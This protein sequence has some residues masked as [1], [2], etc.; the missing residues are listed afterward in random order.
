MTSVV[1]AQPGE[2]QTRSDTSPS[3]ADEL[4]RRHRVKPLAAAGWWFRTCGFLLDLPML[5]AWVLLSPWI[6]YLVVARGRSIG[7]LQERFGIWRISLPTRERI[8]IH[9]ASVG[10]VRASVSL[11]DTLRKS[12]P[13]SEMVIST[14]T[15]GARDL[16]R[17]LFD[18][19]QVHLLPLDFSPLVQAVLKRL[20]PD[21][22]ILIELE[23]WPNLLLACRSRSIPVVVM[24]GRITAK[25][26]GRLRMLGPLT[27]WMASCPELICARS[28][29][30]ASRF[31]QLGVAPERVR[32]PGD[33]KLDSLRGPDP[34]SRRLEFDRSCGV[35]V[36]LFRWS[37]GCT[38]PGEEELMLAAH[39][40]LL[41]VWPS[42]QLWIGPR[43]VE[44]AAEVVALVRRCGLEGTL[45]SSQG[46]GTSQVV[47]IDRLGRLDG[48]YRVSDAAFVG[49]SLVA[50]GGHNLME[51]VAAG[52][53]TCHG[54]HVENF[55]E[56]K[57]LLQRH[58]AVQEV[59]DEHD[60]LRLLSLWASDRPSRQ[61]RHARV[62]ELLDELGGATERCCKHLAEVLI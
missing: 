33:I 14:M 27:K 37:A 44:R 18:D 34:V 39:I 46:S 45:E 4:A 13:G 32:I 30:D 25:G 2:S 19:H 52:C 10:E 49:G 12:R 47:V 7:S 62:Q 42:S 59:A 26:L 58:G 57:T 8:W 53:F 29:E 35:S 22:L 55:R 61:Q 1:Q 50:R 17:E 11:V 31:L 15:T 41:E 48:A 38:H 20:R 3:S 16:A 6:L 40:K 36:D 51:P 56:M 43:H 23:W 54:P 9:A 60:L 5:V 21:V 24:N 28:D